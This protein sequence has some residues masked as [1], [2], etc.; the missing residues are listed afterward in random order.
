[1]TIDQNI[2]KRDGV[3]GTIREC[4]FISD[5]GRGVHSQARLGPRLAILLAYQRGLSQRA[6]WGDIDQ[7]AVLRHLAAEIE[8]EES[9]EATP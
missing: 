5:L 6:R 1:M 2:P 4:N 3:H 7:D 8:A 9:M